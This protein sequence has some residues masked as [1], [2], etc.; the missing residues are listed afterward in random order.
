MFITEFYFNLSTEQK[1]ISVNMKNY[2][3]LPDEIIVKGVEKFTLSI[4]QK[5]II[6]K[7]GIEVTESLLI[8]FNLKDIS[9]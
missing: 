9:K 2:Q 4:F 7:I 6:F 5:K 8:A 1:L 3:E